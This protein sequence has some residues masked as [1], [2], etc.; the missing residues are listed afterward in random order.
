MGALLKR[1]FSWLARAGQ[2][3][4]ATSANR[5][6]A[7]QAGPI[8]GDG[9]APVNGFDILDKVISLPISTWRYQWEGEDVRHIGP[10]S[11]DWKRVFGLGDEYEGIYCVDAKG[12]S[13]VS[14]Q[15]LHRLIITLQDQVNQL[16][17]RLDED[18]RHKSAS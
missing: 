2:P 11:Q 13:L 9:S 1:V 16:E 17:R 14:I 18:P 3:A 15:A 7:L 10:M 12:I 4:P 6:H 5:P 8:A